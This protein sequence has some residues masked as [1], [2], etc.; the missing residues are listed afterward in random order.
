MGVVAQTLAHPP[1]EQRGAISGVGASS[2]ALAR[3]VVAALDLAPRCSQ[4]APSHFLFRWG[5]D[6]AL[7]D[8][9]RP[10]LRSPRAPRCVPWACGT[11]AALAGSRVGASSRALARSV[12]AALDLA[13]RCSQG[14]PSHT[15]ISLGS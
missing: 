4:G 3:S 8:H 11:F 5:L 9:F 7:L 6:L 2:R 15:F 12:V 10:A 14:A 13:P 1:C